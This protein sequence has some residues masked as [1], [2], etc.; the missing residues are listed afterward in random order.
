MSRILNVEK[1]ENKLQEVKG[2]GTFLSYVDP[3]E[4]L[5]TIDLVFLTTLTSGEILVRK[6]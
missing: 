2:L 1:T 6:I 5:A 4:L 3:D